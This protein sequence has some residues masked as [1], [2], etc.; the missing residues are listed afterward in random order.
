MSTSAGG[1]LAG[2]GKPVL[3]RAGPGTHALFTLT[4]FV[5]ALLLFSLQPLFAKMV[6]PVLG[7]APS[8]WAVALCFFQAA[9]LA[10]YCYAH[11]LIQKVPAAST[12]FVH[13]AFCV[14]AFIALP[15]ALPAGAAEP[16]PGD[17]YFWQLELFTVA[18]G[19]PFMAVAANAP[20]LQAWFARTGH[21][22]G[23]DPYFLYAA[24]NL[25]S[26]LALLSYPLVLEPAFG[27]TALSRAWSIG[28]GI[29]VILLGACFWVMRQSVA[30]GEFVSVT[31]STKTATAQGAAPGWGQRGTWIW[32]SFVPAAL[33]TA[34]TTHVAT[35]IASA[36]LVWVLPLALYL[37]T[38]VMV[39]REKAL[40]PPRA[41]LAVHLAAVVLALLHLSQNKHQ[42]WYLSA[43][44]GTAAFFSAALVAHR[45]LY[46]S[47]PSAARLTSFY[48]FMSLGGAL[49]GIFASLVA[50]KL[51]S[52]VLEYPLLL[53]LTF[54]CRPGA[55]KV[56]ISGGELQKL[57][58]IAVAAIVAIFVLPGIATKIGLDFGEWGITPFIAALLAA[59]II[60]FWRLPA[61]QLAA[62]LAMFA[63]VAILPSNVHRG[64]AERSYFGVY[65]VV[66]S[67][68]GEYNVLQHGTTLHGA[69]HI[70]G[71]DGQK[72]LDNTPCTYYHPKGPMAQAIGT[73]RM[74]LAEG[75]K[76]GRFGIIGL[77]AGSLACHSDPDETWRFYEIDPV[78]ERIAKSKH[79][80]FLAN[81]QPKADV[82]IGDARLTLA[83]EK[84]ESFD[85]LVV[86]AFSS[87]AIPMHLITAEALRL[88]ASKLAPDGLGVLHVSNRYLDLESV[89]SATLPQVPELRAL[90]IDDPSRSDGYKVTPSSVVF[91]AKDQRVLHQ[92]LRMRGSRTLNWSDL[93]PWTDDTSDIIGPFLARWRRHG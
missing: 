48:L 68:D 40:I 18:I 89:L 77:G 87:D 29:L 93:R 69:Q 11:F 75:N 45:T 3:D 73:S 32:L 79:F 39:F 81:C 57:A 13:V 86:D 30:T 53:A 6:L 72:I 83:K 44:L 65:R 59:A 33:L 47:R 51:F 46:E 56:N 16:P 35:D 67:E 23:G 62:A 9:L 4:T 31:T 82:V 21:A 84:D 17:A 91:I 2:A 20:L 42:T 54:A 66:L 78:V 63:A 22:Q 60:A 80:T 5:S 26:L 52:E 55:L 50:P 38:F 36:P 92:Y 25:G 61:M 19:L 85:V 1:A 90:A 10:G 12:G 15:I 28:F 7:G 88:Y 58:L 70:G 24:S 71:P 34:F 8:V 74:R 43:A 76:K 41:L 49:G 14:L 37:L 27:L 64:T